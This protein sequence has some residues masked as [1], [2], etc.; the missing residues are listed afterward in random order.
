MSVE[1][2]R[3]TESTPFEILTDV[4]NGAVPEV[5]VL[6]VQVI[7]TVPLSGVPDGVTTV[8]WI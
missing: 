5:L 8:S 2:A 7:T 6:P 1:G 4:L 3:S